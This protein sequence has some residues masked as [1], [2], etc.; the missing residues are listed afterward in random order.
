M[1]CEPDALEVLP[2]LPKAPPSEGAQVDGDFGRFAGPLHTDQGQP[3]DLA[4]VD[5]FPLAVGIWC[6]RVFTSG[7]FI[8]LEFDSAIIGLTRSL[9]IRNGLQ[10]NFIDP[11]VTSTPRPTG[12]DAGLARNCGAA[13]GPATLVTLLTCLKPETA[14]PISPRS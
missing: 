10:W 12:D 2:S 5:A 4:L 8:R 9:R 3:L 7:E 14:C 1:R 6:A 13:V 11:R